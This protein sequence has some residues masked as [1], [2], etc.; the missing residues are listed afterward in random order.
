MNLQDALSQEVPLVSH[1]AASFHLSGH[2]EADTDPNYVRLYRDAMNKRSYYLINKDDIH[3]D[4]HKWTDQELAQGGFFGQSRHRI[5]LRYG[6]VIS[7]VTVK[8]HRIGDTIAGDTTKR[9]RP[10]AGECE[11]SPG[12][13]GHNCC[14]YGEDGECYCDDCCEA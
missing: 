11:Y 12:C 4:V 9:A 5:S 2:L 10:L 14:T 7:A 13:G 6:T 1:N 8:F 3:E